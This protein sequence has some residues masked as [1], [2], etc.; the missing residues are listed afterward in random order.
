MKDLIK[1]QNYI[2]LIDVESKEVRP[3]PVATNT[4]S[5]EF[6]RKHLK[7]R[8][9]ECVELTK[10]VD[11]WIDEEG[12]INDAY[13]EKGMFGFNGLVNFAGHGLLMNV[14]KDGDSIPFTWEELMTIMYSTEKQIN[15]APIGYVSVN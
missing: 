2:V 10:G 8:M 1:N 3:I 12:M 9:V 11:L 5:L 7:C 4:V 15:F 6:M 14:N 13:R